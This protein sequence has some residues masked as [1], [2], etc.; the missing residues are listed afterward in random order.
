MNAYF[1]SNGFALRDRLDIQSP[2]F[3]NI[4][5]VSDEDLLSHAIDYFDSI[6]AER[7]GP[8][9]SLIMSTS[10]HKPFTF[11]AGVPDVPSSGGGRLAGVRYAD[12]AIGEFFEIVKTKPW[13]KNTIFVI[14]ADHDSRVYGRAYIPVDRYRIPALIYAP[15]RISPSINEKMFSSLDVAP[16]VMGLLGLPYEG[17]F[18]GVDVLSSKVPASRP[19]MFSHNHNIAWYEGEKLTVLGLQKE[20]R[21]FN[22][23]D[24]KTTEATLD[25]D[26]ADVL[27]AHLQTAYELF[28]AHRY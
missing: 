26:A 14:I 11:R 10:N 23:Q 9:F 15:G 24:G 17:P 6:D 2:R 25:V 19:V 22:Y 12:F 8:F 27:A 1:G 28:K 13:F 20:A 16:T 21:T 5:G 18:Y 4:W 3:T 7:N